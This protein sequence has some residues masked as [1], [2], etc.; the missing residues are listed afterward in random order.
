MQAFASAPNS[1][2]VLRSKVANEAQENPKDFGKPLADLDVLLLWVGK[3]SV[4]TC[5]WRIMCL[6]NSISMSGRRLEPMA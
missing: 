6:M 5:R 4:T 1:F 3:A 2:V